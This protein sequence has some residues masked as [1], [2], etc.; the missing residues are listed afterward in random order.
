MR[1]ISTPA[2]YFRKDDGYRPVPG[3]YAPSSRTK[4]TP[5]REKNTVISLGLPEISALFPS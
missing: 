5:I 2:G 3:V 1:G 4:D